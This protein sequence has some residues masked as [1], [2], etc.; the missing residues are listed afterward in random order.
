M[1]PSWR[2]QKT[3]I[4]Q[5]QPLIDSLDTMI[6]KD[7]NTQLVVETQNYLIAITSS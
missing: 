4:S 5:F 3:L 1:T 6:M 2:R 7:Q